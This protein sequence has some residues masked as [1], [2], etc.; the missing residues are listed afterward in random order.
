[1][2]VL[3]SNKWLI[4]VTRNKCNDSINLLSSFKEKIEGTDQTASTQAC[5]PIVCS[6]I[7]SFHSIIDNTKS[8]LDIIDSE[9]QEN[10][11]TST[12]YNFT[13]FRKKGKAP[14]EEVVE[15]VESVE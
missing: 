6:I 14:L 1:M 4:E 3:Q 10:T 12:T 9:P 15:V 8:A 13:T 5:L 2:S 7:D 11:P